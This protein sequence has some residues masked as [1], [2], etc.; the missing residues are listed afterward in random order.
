MQKEVL[1]IM[2]FLSISNTFVVLM[3][4]SIV[5]IGLI[6]INILCKIMGLFCAKFASNETLSSKSSEI[7]SS[8]NA[9]DTNVNRQ[10]ML[11]AVSA[12]IA[13]ELGTDVKAIRIHS[14]KKL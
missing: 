3:G 8:N 14:V 9:S 5:F 2:W 12:A 4:L 7:I 10:E 11:A 13:E 1:K 6:C